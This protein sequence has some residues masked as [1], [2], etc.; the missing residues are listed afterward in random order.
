MTR[1][2]TTFA[3]A[4]VVSL[5]LVPMVR[6]LARTCGYIATPKKERWHKRPTPLLG[7]A[8]LSLTVIGLMLL[9]DHPEPVWALLVAAGVMF[10]VGLFDDLRSLKPSTKL[11][12]QVAVASLLVF[13]GYRLEWVESLTG[14]T[15]LTLVWIVG[16]T[17]A[18]NLLDNMD[19]LCTGVALIAGLSLL[20]AFGGPGMDSPSVTYLVL[21]LGACAGFLV[22]NVHP[23][24]IF[25]GDSGSLFIGVSLATLALGLETTA[26]G[27]PNVLAVI[28]VPAFVLLIP[29]FDTTLVTLSRLVSGRT[30][31]MGGR[32]HSS[33][34]L[35]AI[36]LSERAAVMVL[37]A[38]AGVGGFVGVF[39]R[40][41][42]P[43]W[44]MLL[45]ALVLLAMG[46][47][48][49]YLSHVRVYD[50]ADE[51]V[52]E[53]G[54]VTPLVV[55]FL[56]KRRVVEVLLDVALVSVAY[57]AAYRLRFEGRAWFDNFDLFFQSLPIA[58]GVQMLSLFA[59]GAYRGVWR[60]FTL[61]DA[62]VLVNSVVVGTL[63]TVAVLVVG[64]RFEAY[65]RTVFGI[66]A[67]VLV[68]LLI[69]SRS[70]FRLIS[71]LVR[72]RRNSGA[73]LVVYGAD[74]AGIVGL[75][76]LSG[77]LDSRLR[78][79]GF[80]DD[81]RRRHGQRVHGYLVLGG[82]DK[83]LTLIAAGDVDTVVLCA[84]VVDAGRLTMLKDACASNGV[85]LSRM[86]MDM[87]HLIAG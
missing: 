64:Y 14:D 74:D 80:I 27:Q 54:T 85:A 57:Y 3:V 19:G 37:W 51:S 13:Y 56:Y 77:E 24:S 52:L 18:F 40:Y 44:S 71:E 78:M 63:V 15:L 82:H 76:R 41:V 69:S 39:A 70:S 12:A 16:I 47:F 60:Y 20:V 28:A 72:R 11:V 23:A 87:K 65:S 26:G 86:H 1:L 48:A 10:S 55:D 4:F 67:V 49:V 43:D 42:S 84:T 53:S 50:D 58:V 59:V 46:M 6:H 66:Y 31:A 5:A 33:H 75:R 83:L 68:V 73:R 38:L 62:M 81:D 45:A 29:I 9:A 61:V 7:G 22:Y 32:D 34:R 2:L 21:L 36:G 25:L 79:L 17:N 30:P 8:A 35:V